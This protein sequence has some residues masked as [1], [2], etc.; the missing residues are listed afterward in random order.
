[1]NT[2]QRREP[3]EAKYQQ[4]ETRFQEAV[5]LRQPDRVPIVLF[6]EFFMTQYQGLTNQQ[7]MYDCDRMVEAS[8]TSMVEFDWDMAPLPIGM[9]SGPAMD[10]L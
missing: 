4:R 6:A 7:A 8:K 10:L 2:T 5:A 9:L 1:M 3:A